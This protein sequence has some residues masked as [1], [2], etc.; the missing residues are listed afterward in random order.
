M[1]FEEFPFYRVGQK[2]TD[3]VSPLLDIRGNGHLDGNF[4]T[5]DPLKNGSIDS[6]MGNIPRNRVLR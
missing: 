4:D 3:Q 6:S 2:M 5:V 1:A